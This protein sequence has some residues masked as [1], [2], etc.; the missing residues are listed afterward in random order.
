MRVGR[1]TYSEPDG[2][3]GVGWGAGAASVLLLTERLD[4]DWIS[5]GSLRFVS[6]QCYF[7]RLE[8]VIKSPY[9]CFIVVSLP[10]RL[11]SRGLMSKMSTPSIFPKISRRSRPVACSKSVAMVPDAAP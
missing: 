10:V 6:F 11:E 3:V 7:I 8:Y 2:D 5:D 4:H 9:A 1:K